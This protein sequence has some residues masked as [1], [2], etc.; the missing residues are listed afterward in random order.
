MMLKRNKGIRSLFLAM[1]FFLL[2]G[3]FLVGSVFGTE[4]QTM[5]VLVEEAW[6][7]DDFDA[8]TSGWGTTHFASIQDGLNGLTEN[9]TLHIAT[10]IY[11]ESFLVAKDGVT[12]LGQD[13]SILEGSGNLLHNGITIQASGVILDGLTVQHWNENGIH[14]EGNDNTVQNCLIAGNGV[15]S[16]S[17][18]AGIKVEGNGNTISENTADS[19]GK[20]GIYILG[21]ENVVQGNSA[22]NNGDLGGWRGIELQGVDNQILQNTVNENNSAGIK[23][24][25]NSNGLSIGNIIQGNT[26]SKNRDDGMELRGSTFNVSN[27][28]LIGN[29][30]NGI[31]MVNNDSNSE[32]KGNVVQ[33]N[34]EY[35][36][37]SRGSNQI[38]GNTV[39][40][41]GLLERGHTG[42]IRVDEGDVLYA[43]RIYDNIN[44][45]VYTY[46]GYV[47]VDEVSESNGIVPLVAEHNWW[48]SGTGPYHPTT[49]PY[50]SG[51]AVRDNIDFSPW[52]LTSEDPVELTDTK[53]FHLEEGESASLQGVVY[54]GAT[55]GNG[56]LT[57]GAYDDNPT[58]SSFYGELGIYADV[59]VA[60]P[61]E[62][63]ELMIRLF[64]EGDPEP[65][66]EL[67]L[68]WWNGSQWAICS[69]T[70]VNRSENY[71][72]AIVGPQTTPALSH[73][74]GSEFGIGLMEPEP[75]EPTEE[76]EPEATPEEP[77]EADNPKTGSM[78]GS[79]IP[80]LVLAASGW[81]MQRKR[82]E[83]K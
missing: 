47:N 21:D 77:A 49:N 12:I 67:V 34:K 29:G 39:T 51:D 56:I 41:N 6:V 43:N 82:K 31:H 59:Q 75:E 32:L 17:Y 61:T 53:T 70:G 78:T 42:G 64:Y 74:I 4:S 71:V 27:N 36:I 45:G 37:S 63:G 69:N 23:A 55:D 24:D 54:V 46:Y 72:W 1:I 14:I 38:Q 25:S 79:T 44:Y 57:L 8:G 11:E 58:N 50:G 68:Y 83:H 22:S 60:Q 33:D 9:G 66:E 40:G 35:G 26:V 30:S 48:G 18:T 10:G 13:G 5:A 16:T 7:D 15:A 80:W 52:L 3:I 19:N 65:E 73:L 81:M 2:T 28:T 76:E 20:I 62:L